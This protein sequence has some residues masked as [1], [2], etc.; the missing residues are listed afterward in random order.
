MAQPN[1]APIK[2]DNKVSEIQKLNS[3]NEW[4]SV[5]PGELKNKVNLEKKSRFGNPGPDQ[6]YAMVLFKR[7]TDDIR[8]SK[9]EDIHDVQA[10]VVAIAM[11]RAAIFGRAPVNKDIEFA[12]NKFDFLKDIKSDAV[13]KR[14]E[15]FKSAGHEYSK[16]QDI[17]DMIDEDEMKSYR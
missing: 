13:K 7:F 10:G 9:E 2:S 3:P 4:K 11:K 12:L 14:R 15:T 6:G 16:R 17:A 5:R 8:L 1:F